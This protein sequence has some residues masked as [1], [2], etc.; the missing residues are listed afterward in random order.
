MGLIVRTLNYFHPDN[1]ELFH[2]LNFTFNDGEKAAL[3]GINGAGK[4]TLLRLIAGK[5]QLTSGEIS[6]SK[7]P[8]YVP[9]HLGEY[10]GWSIAQA[11][12]ADKKL[13]ALH[14][15]LGGDTDIRH[16][17]NLDDDWDIENKVEKALEK[18]G[19]GSFD[20]NR[21]LRSLSGGQKTKVFLAAL[22]MNSPDLILLDEPSNHL[23]TITRNKLY[24]LIAQSKATMLIVSHDRTLLNLMN[25]TMEL[26]KKGIEVFGG[27]FEFYQEKKQEKV[28]ALNAQLNDQSKS[29]KQ[30]E[31]KAKDMAILRAGQES[32]GRSAGLSNSIPRII[33]GGLK[34]KAQRSTARMLDAHNE[35]IAGLNENIRETKA[36]IQ[37]Y[38]A[39]KIE[40]RHSGLPHG[41][42]F[43]DATNIN[44]A[45]SGN[46]LWSRLNFQIKSGER[47]QIEGENGVGKTTLLRII[48]GALKPLEGEYNSTVFSYLYLDQDYTMIDSKR[49]I[50]EQV[51]EYN[52]RGLEEHELKALL[53]HSQFDHESFDRKC[54]GLS[55]GE[56]MKL[57]LCC[58]VVN[59]LAPD[60][61]ILDEP[62]NNLDVQ[63]LEVLTS[64]IKNFGGTLLV[65][66]HD[67]YFINEIRIDHKII[68]T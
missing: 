18:W 42:I 22:D 53:I 20:L 51:Q 55:G 48:T 36:Q 16:F 60:V 40:I 37:L 31:K 24:C 11:L 35:K 62:T 28:N 6:Y 32:K 46:K 26:S 25:K 65:I 61:L 68:L 52:N 66:S 39:L 63:S 50:Y 45:Y 56:K 4:S 43:I 13:D 7:K 59:N 21:L 19:L 27:N 64:A 57:S 12:D 5:L 49:T 29:L 54:A 2:D 15:I 8:W 1:E 44:Y 33:S 14:A 10:D 41:K 17:N 30:S 9:Q 58:M 23:D 47:V 67:A 3:V 34:S 38:R